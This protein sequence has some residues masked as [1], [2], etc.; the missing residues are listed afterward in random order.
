[1]SLLSFT[2]GTASPPSKVPVAKAVADPA[3]GV[4]GSVVRLDGQESFD[5]SALPPKSGS[6]ATTSAPNNISAPSGGFSLDDVDRII[7]LTGV[8]AGS[9][10]IVSVVSSTQI[11]VVDSGTNATPVFS[12]SS[13]L[14]WSIVDTLTYEWAFESTP[15]GS[16]VV[17]E[18]FRTLDP[19]GM[20]VSFSPDVVGDYVVSLTVSNGSFKSTSYSVRA[21]I[22][23]ILVP[24]ARGIVPDGKWVWSYIRDV[25]TQVENREWFET[26]WSALIQI[27]GSELLKT[28]QTDFNKS[29]RDIQD[30]YQRRWLK[31]EPLLEVLGDDV[32]FYIGNEAAGTDATTQEIGNNGELLILSSNEFLV[33]AGSIYSDAAGGVLSITYDSKQPSNVHDYK[34]LTLNSSKTGYKLAPPTLEYPA[35]DPVPNKILT[36]VNLYFDVQS[37]TWALTTVALTPYAVKL[38]KYSSLIETLAPIMDPLIGSSGAADVNVGDYILINSGVNAGLY[39]ITGKVGSFITVDHA[40]PGGSDT[41]T[42][43]QGDIYRPVG[44]HIDRTPKSLSSS[45][46]IPISTAGSLGSLAPGRV[47]VMGGQTYTILRTYV[48]T[49]QVT[50]VVIITTTTNDVLF[51]FSGLNWRVPHTLVSSSQSFE[52]LGVSQ[53]DLLLLDVLSGESNSVAEVVAQVVGVSGNRIGFVLT[54]AELTPGIVPSVPN[55]S[56]VEVSSKLSVP[57]ATVTP[58]GSLNLTGVAKLIVN[59]INSIEFQRKYWNTPLTTETVVSSNGRTF[60]VVPR[61]IIRNHLI[62]IDPTV[63]SI[64][65]LQEWVVQPEWIQKNG[66]TYQV[67]G[68]QEFEIRGPPLTL[69]ENTDYVVDSIVAFN[70]EL[71]FDSGSNIIE[72]TDGHFIDRGLRPGDEFVISSPVTLSGTYFISAVQSQD[73]LVLSST[74]PLYALSKS[75]RAKVSINR[76][77]SGTFVRFVPGGFSP[78]NPAPERFWAEVTLFDNGE[79]IENNFGLLVGL[80]RADLEAVTETINYRQAVAGLMYAYTRGS[81][82]DE[83]RLGAQILLGL[84]F[85]ESRGI[86]RSIETDYRLDALG[87]PVQGRM[88]IED[89]DNNGNLLGTM[90]VYTFPLDSNSVLSGVETNP[91]TGATYKVGDTVELFAALSKG[92]EV[93]DYISRPSLVGTSALQK[94]QQF[95]TIRMRA[96]DSIFTLPELELVSKFLKQITPSYVRFIMMSSSELED[97]VK[98]TD[99]VVNKIGVSPLVDNASFGLS[100][101][102]MLDN[103]TPSGY[104]TIFGTGAYVVR[105]SGKDLSTTYNPSSPSNAVISAA[106]GLITPQ[107]GEG[108]VTRIGDILHIVEG[109][110]EGFYPINTVVSDT[111]LYLNDVPPKGLNTAVQRFAIL[112]PVTG[113][114]RSGDA[115]TTSGDPLVV[116]DPGLIDAGAM[117]GDLLLIDYGATA[118][119]HTI[120][121]VGPLASPSPVTSG[122]VRVTPTPTVT[123]KGTSKILRK[124]LMESPFQSITGTLVSSGTGYTSLSP[125]LKELCEVNDEIQVQD[126]TSIR[127]LALDPKNLYFVPVLPAGS[128]TVKLCIRGKPS[129]PV[130]MSHLSV[131]DPTDVLDVVLVETDPAA[132]TCVALS[133]QVS[134]Q[135]WASGPGYEP[136]DPVLRGVKPGDI[137]VLT[138]GGNSTVDVGYGPGVYPIIEVDPTWVA[139]AVGLTTSDPSGWK[140]LRRR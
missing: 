64:P 22:R 20:E 81:A 104:G 109:P 32:T 92:V 91:A 63:K 83:V 112:R 43:T 14:N 129:G 123:D 41:V 73:K 135:Q 107:S 117:Q 120:L 28:Y 13:S 105:K 47:I 130:G 114:I 46:A 74:V 122:I 113:E 15:I 85:A 30:L 70:G 56:Y 118:A 62:P 115:S 66:K 132:A 98:V 60:R 31:Y 108:P 57:T 1:M 90:R 3:Y 87:S 102:L 111:T 21:S 27:T 5:P 121:E 59:Y 93:I 6:D 126:Q 103:K 44:F 11:Q 68:Q 65:M 36:A 89:T 33:V 54:D 119:L 127:L 78:L 84:P 42:T 4:V 26:F 95:H 128:Y 29:I 106:G 16:R 61:G 35:P 38:S 80:T 88:L 94:L 12:G 37:T 82:I 124:S 110:N 97:D 77:R 2:T 52:D 125:A 23:A 134:L 53:G 140:I 45:F 79:S 51:G 39:K 58:Y 133:N 50:P 75:V 116:L 71:V 100:T 139:V 19:S 137:L 55:K 10:R 24:H 34:I 72:V 86:I 48:D 8:D 136:F 9:Y 17:Q 49:H 69:V 7:T 131:F 25:W 67:K 96:N 99:V 138:D 40:P 101:T 18:G 76:K